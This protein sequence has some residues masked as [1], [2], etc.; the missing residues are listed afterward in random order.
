MYVSSISPLPKTKPKFLFRYIVLSLQVTW[1][2]FKNGGNFTWRWLLEANLSQKLLKKYP[3]FISKNLIMGCFIY[4]LDSS[5][6]SSF[7]FW[8]SEFTSSS[9]SNWTGIW[10][11]NSNGSWT[12]KQSS[13]FSTAKV[14][15][16]FFCILN[17]NKQILK[18]CWNDVEILLN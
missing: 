7:T 4:I 3:K 13:H 11:G 2:S 18:W 14:K 17:S 16:T 6:S 1:Q 5:N 15:A 10:T 12:D 8:Y 9:R